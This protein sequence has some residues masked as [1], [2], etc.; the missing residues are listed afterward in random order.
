MVN[1]FLA[2][3]D[4]YG[5]FIIAEISLLHCMGSFH[6]S[7][8]KFRKMAGDVFTDHIVQ[9]LAMNIAAFI[10]G[11]RSLFEK[12]SRYFMHYCLY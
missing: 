3:N 6:I 11:Y 2:G 1:A 12:K 10:C 8:L 4:Y 7:L 9:N 5:Y